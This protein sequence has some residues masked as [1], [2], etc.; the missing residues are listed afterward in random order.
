LRGLPL[1]ALQ[2]DLLGEGDVEVVRSIKTLETIDE[3]PA[4]EFW[5]R[6][7][8]FA[9]TLA[10][11]GGE[12]SSVAGLS[13]DA[14]RQWV[15]GARVHGHRPLFV[16]GCGAGGSPRFAGFARKD[17]GGP[18]WELRSDLTWAEYQSAFDELGARGYYPPSTTGYLAGPSVRY[19]AVWVRS[20]LPPRYEARHGLRPNDYRDKLA[21]LKA[22][23]RRPLF[24]SPYPDGAGSYLVVGLFG[25]AGPAPWEALSELSAGQYE[26]AKDSWRAK[27]FHPVHLAAYDGG[28]GARF[29]VILLKDEARWAARI[30]LTPEQY[31]AETEKEIGEGLA[32]ASVAGY[33]D[34]G[35]LRYAAVWL[36]KD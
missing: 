7:D 5:A 28:D 1:T 23:G 30:G 29:A 27:G 12:Y 25:D 14:F 9:R 8:A 16:N 13:G 36:R 24:A 21:V 3:T 10:G 6:H 33:G 35:A 2:C 26:S 17:V 11:K 18:A 4:A 22:E 32:P 15:E 31:R 20:P 19:T 34:G